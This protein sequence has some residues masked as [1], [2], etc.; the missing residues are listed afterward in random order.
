[1][2]TDH[3]L[4]VRLKSFLN[5]TELIN[6]PTAQ[7]LYKSYCELNNNAVQ[8]LVEC[9][10]L[11]QKKQ[12]IEAV[13]LAQQEPN[14]FGLIDTLLFP[15]RKDLL[16]LADL[17]DWVVPSEINVD[18][19]AGLKKAVSEMD[20]L[21]PLLTEFRRIAR[22]DQVK[23][24]L[25]LLREISRIDKGN[26]EW[27]LPLIEVE[28]QYVSRIISEAQKAIQDKNFS[29][30]EQIFAELKNSSWVVT[31]PTIVLQKIEKIVVEHRCAEAKRIAITILDRINSSYASFDVIG[32]DDAIV[33]WNEHCKK[34]NYSPDENEKMQLKE[35]NIY[36]SSE[37]KKQKAEHEFQTLLE[38]I[39]SLMNSSSPLSQVE[40]YFAKAQSF[41][42][43]IP[44]YI[45]NRVEKYRI[46]TERE[47]RTATIIRSL[48]IVGTV[49]VILWIIVGAAIWGIQSK[50]E[51]TQS[52]NLYSVIKE[53][54]IV[55]AQALLKEIETRYPKLSSRPK[56]SKAKAAL[57]EL[58]SSDKARTDEFARI[59]NE[60]NE[61]KKQ[62]PP[63]KELKEKVAT[64]EKLAKTDIE[65][66]RVR[67]AQ[68]WVDAAFIRRADEVEELF[69]KKI[70]MLK[71]CRDEI[72][73]C[74][75]KGEFDQ[76]EKIL[77]KLEKIHYEITSLEDVNKD[78][79]AD[80]KEL[81][82]SSKILKEVLAAKKNRSEELANALKT[83]INAENFAAIEAAIRS[84]GRILD[85]NTDSE[86]LKIID[87][88]IKEIS[89]FKA[90]LNFQGGNVTSVPA[91]YVDSAYFKDIKNYEAHRKKITEAKNEIA[92]AFDSLQKNTNH[93]KII[94]IRVESAGSNK[95][96]YASPR[97]ISSMGDGKKYEIS[98]RS[99]DGTKV[100]L[101]G[102][103]KNLSLTIGDEEF[104]NC[105][106]R[107]PKQLT[108]SAIRASRAPHQDLIEKFFTEIHTMND[109]ETLRSGIKYLEMIKEHKTCAP[110]WKMKLFLRILEPLIQIDLSPNKY[111]SKMKDE[112]IK[113]QA[114][115]N[116][117]GDPLE[118]KFLSDKVSLFFKT[119]DFSP[120]EKTLAQ[121]EV[122][123]NFYKAHKI[124]N[125]QCLGFAANVNKNLRYAIC[126]NLKS[127]ET[128][129]FCFD[130]KMSGI[131]LVGRYGKSGLIIDDKFQD[132]VAG[133]LLFTSDPIDS[134]TT[135]FNGLKSNKVD[136][137]LQ[138]IEWPE[139][140]PQN[141]RGDAK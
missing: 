33:C 45:S 100:V 46:D 52:H 108:P 111:L 92:A 4:I 37:K 132:K 54:K 12:K 5:S 74:I 95:D 141:M 70:T 18:S 104:Q 1:M 63:D 57:Q 55:E 22:T 72:L 89:Y 67:E 56:I 127:V 41:G 80:N 131:M 98:L 105:I 42:L 81:L 75:K 44:D 11:L 120:L 3:Q 73:A 118:N 79:L 94:F 32:L 103:P 28:N 88:C 59:L 49:V 39:T 17:Y 77:S 2:D 23:N 128:E 124:S 31:I 137:D 86:E 123:Q 61:L 65:K 43:E 51:D 29:R 69:L 119:Y 66:D 85:K 64:I 30:L 113:L 115:D 47:H 112:L 76:A 84:Y 71:K 114:L 58:I 135:L 7:E 93:Q 129:V 38:H 8:R 40:K 136:I 96:I 9:E 91:E 109:S 101:K 13:V 99:T 139:F 27:R 35:A 107:C 87:Q 83:I 68:S 97:G 140:W 122:L 102:R 48:K 62:W 36:L 126:S 14:L 133:H 10:V 26:P 138:K 21:R 78:L 130:E 25:H 60:I 19:V 110:Y 6:S 134:I 34:Y 20:D 53:G 15:E 117:A 116:M 125:M 121:N 24:K 50:I 16:V 82:K 90:I 106:L